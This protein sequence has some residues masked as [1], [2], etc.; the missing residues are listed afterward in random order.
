MT[1]NPPKGV[2]SYPELTPLILIAKP[3]KMPHQYYEVA[4]PIEQHH[5]TYNLHCWLKTDLLDIYLIF[6]CKI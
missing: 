2:K 4:L 3:T 6:P 1:Q 5:Q